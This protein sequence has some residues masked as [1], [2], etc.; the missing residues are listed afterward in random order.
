MELVYSNSS[1]VDENLQPTNSS[2][3][4]SSNSAGSDLVSLRETRLF[5]AWLTIK[6]GCKKVYLLPHEA[7]NSSWRF[8]VQMCVLVGFFC[9]LNR[10]FFLN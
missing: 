9:F 2:A 6:L 8:A 1:S 5:L 3:Y 4:Q 7:S 10:D